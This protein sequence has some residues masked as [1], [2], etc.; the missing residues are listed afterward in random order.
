MMTVLQ[1][2]LANL[3]VASLLAALATL[4]GRFWRRPALVHSLWLLVLLKLVTP[5]L[6]PLPVAWLEH[7]DTTAATSPTRATATPAGYQVVA[8]AP[9]TIRPAAT[10]VTVLIEVRPG[11]LLD[12]S[13][14]LFVRDPS[15][16]MARETEEWLLQNAG[17]L[18]NESASVSAVEV[19]PAAG[20]PPAPRWTWGTVLAS[21]G[22][23]WLAGSVA[24]FAW[25]TLCLVRFQR[26][27][28]CATPAPPELQEQARALAARLG[29]RRGPAVWLIPGPL[30][31]MIWAAFGPAR[32]LFP[33]QLLVRLDA[34]G[35]AALLAHELAHLRRRDHWVRWL[36]LLAVGLYWWCP[37]SWWARRQLQVHEEE[38]CDAWVVAELPPRA[39]AS[40]ILETIDFLADA[41]PRL[42]A[43]ASGLGRLPS[44][45]KRLTAIM[46]RSTPRRLS[47]A[48]WLAVLACA[49]LL[50]VRPTPARP[51]VRPQGAPRQDAKPPV[52]SAPVLPEALLFDPRPLP[53]QSAP[54]PAECAVLS[55]DG[56]LLAAAYGVH[57][58]PGEVRVWDLATGN[59][60]FAFKEPAG[61]RSVV[62]SPDGTLLAAG[63]FSNLVK[64]RDATTGKVLAV[65]RGHT[66]AVNSVAFRP[67]GKTLASASLDHTVRLW[68]VYTHQPKSILRGHTDWVFSVAFSPDGKTLASC[69]RDRTA[70]LWD[71]DTGKEQFVLKGH[72]NAIE[73]VVF[74][75][76]S[77]TVAT[78]SWDRSVKLWDV[79]TGRLKASLGGHTSS[80]MCIAFS[81]DGKTIATG[82]GDRTIKLW[83]AATN[84]V[85]ATLEGHTDTVFSIAF[86]ADGKKLVS[87]SPDT[88]VRLWDVADRKEVTMYQRPGDR[89]ED[90]PVVLALNYSPDGKTLAVG[91][92]DRNVSLRDVESG[93]L[94]R[95]LTGHEDVVTGVCFS[96][97]G[98]TI[99]TASPDRTVRLWDAATGKEVR[100]LKGHTSWVYA[101]AFSADG[102]TLASAG[103]DKTIRLW[104]P[105]TGKEK[106]TLLGHTASIRALAF[107]PDDKRLA[108]AGSDRIIRLWDLK[109][110]EEQGKLQG[111][112]GT[113]RALAF[114]PDGATLASAAEDGARL[115]DVLTGK[116]RAPLTGHTGE[117]WS[118]GYS[119]QGK[120]VITGGAD[121]TVRVWDAGS[122]QL[123]ATLRGHTDGVA[124]VAL[125]PGGRQLASGS[126]DKTVKLWTG[127]PPSA[128]T[129]TKKQ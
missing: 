75:P 94:L 118:L 23:L 58:T 20:S 81:A 117:V 97:D 32:L 25:V 65:L 1:V 101:V 50:P 41:W 12:T 2:A 26:L 100:V 116:T 114:A 36:E 73:M 84:Q 128:P 129:A 98:T 85:L 11:V 48:G 49:A 37:L 78:A 106:G 10:R 61:V 7:P 19:A 71:V 54:L 38:C 6:V 3:V 46:Q 93:L 57:N 72:A 112:Q 99:A 9:P 55:P 52:P 103:Y 39:Y 113:V 90:R 121:T 43:A 109:T 29:L 69:G 24:W 15:Q 70:R 22:W 123:R 42:P 110:L 68:D 124:A 96:P 4:A 17:S 13:T 62:F 56:Q 89:A 105:T 77:A 34:D 87:A 45:K 60:R 115:W 111:H 67:D 125:A 35:R 16:V 53:L 86:T 14:G 64:L 31:P 120:S 40:A 59:V 127:M 8:L 82:S 63:D 76:D 51:A 126:H 107:S 102:K 33:A 21:A 74:A 119:P 79:A 66:S 122:G 91:T 92:E 18:A 83:D 47:R 104:D 95:T 80:A 108:S 88:T 27:L 28:R 30:P 44:L 5:P